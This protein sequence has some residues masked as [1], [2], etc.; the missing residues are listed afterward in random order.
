MANPEKH[1]C[2]ILKKTIED[3]LCWEM[4]FADNLISL[5]SIPELVEWLKRHN[6]E[7]DEVHKNFCSKCEFCQWK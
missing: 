3:G 6:L 2:P 5:D 1:N 4:C 7:L